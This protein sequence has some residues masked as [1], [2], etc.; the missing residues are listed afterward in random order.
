MDNGIYGIFQVFP[1]GFR[2][3]G[4]IDDQRVFADAGD[5]PGEHGLRCVL[6]AV[7]DHGKC[8]IIS[9]ALDDI[10]GG[11]RGDISFGKSGAACGENKIDPL[12]T[13]I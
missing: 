9:S 8:Q 6:Q 3:S 1:Y 5:T 2:A 11:F 4:Q 12:V 10:C 7:G 13:I